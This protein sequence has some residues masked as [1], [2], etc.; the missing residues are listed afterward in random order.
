MVF[1]ISI[2]PRGARVPRPP[3]LGPLHLC[4]W[5]HMKRKVYR[6]SPDTLEVLRERIVTV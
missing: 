6:A 5:G 4:L 2:G 3:D 1:L